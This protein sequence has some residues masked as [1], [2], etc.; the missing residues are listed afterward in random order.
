MCGVAKKKAAHIVMNRFGMRIMC[1]L[2][3]E[4]VGCGEDHFA[5]GWVAVNA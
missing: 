1:C 4:L 5:E 2:F 3:L